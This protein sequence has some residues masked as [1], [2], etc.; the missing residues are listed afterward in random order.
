VAAITPIEARRRGLGLSQAAA[1]DRAG[2]SRS[3]WQSIERGLI[4]PRRVQGAV[5]AVLGTDRAEFWPE[6]DDL[7]I[8]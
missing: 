4:P 5:A 2:I 7:R 3:Y 1:G 8:P 6:E